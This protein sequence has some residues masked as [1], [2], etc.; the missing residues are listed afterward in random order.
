M[1]LQFLIWFGQEQIKIACHRGQD[2]D[3]NKPMVFIDW[4]SMIFSK[5]KQLVWFR[6][7][8]R[9]LNIEACWFFFLPLWAAMRKSCKKNFKLLC[10]YYIKFNEYFEYL[11]NML[12]E[13]S[14]YLLILYLTLRF[15]FNFVRDVVV[16][17]L[18][19][20]DFWPLAW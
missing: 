15:V 19:I 4:I 2:Y 18:K 5:L 1:F 8:N 11:D 14:T 7:V 12:D 10:N 16:K 6:K 13:Y 17:W 20:L 3:T 9:I